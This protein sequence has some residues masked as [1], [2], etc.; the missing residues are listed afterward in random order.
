MPGI[1]DLLKELGKV[2]TFSLQDLL[3]DILK[4][5]QGSFSKKS[6]DSAY[7]QILINTLNDKIKQLEIE[8]ED[9]KHLKKE[10]EKKLK[11]EK[12]KEKAQQHSQKQYEQDY[13]SENWEDYYY[14][15]TVKLDKTLAK[16]YAALEVPY[17]AGWEQVQ[18]S[19]RVLMKKYH[20]DFYAN[21]PEKQKT[22]TVLSQK[23]SEAYQALK[24]HLQK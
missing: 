16:H 23:L 15:K 3:K 10:L 24:K 17:G 12:K 18:K 6:N 13:D 8:L 2:Y 4:K 7:Y 22:A 5:R 9:S 19:Y 1:F 21:E 20:P 11:E 14:E